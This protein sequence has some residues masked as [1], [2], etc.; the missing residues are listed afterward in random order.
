VEGCGEMSD[1]VIDLSKF[2]KQATLIGDVLILK[3][4]LVGKSKM[5]VFKKVGKIE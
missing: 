1:E 5:F 3:F 2:I 4:V